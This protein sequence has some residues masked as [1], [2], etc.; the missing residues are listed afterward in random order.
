M[1]CS[2][3][4]AGLFI[5]SAYNLTFSFNVFG[6]RVS[7]ISF[8]FIDSNLS[9]WALSV[10][11]FFVWTGECCYPGFRLRY[12]G[13]S[14]CWSVAELISVITYS[15]IF[16]PVCSYDEQV[17]LWDGRNMRKPF[18]RSLM[19]GGVW[20]LKWHPTNQSLLLA[21]CMHNNFKILNCQSAF[22]KDDEINNDILLWL[23]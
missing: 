5:N 6:L 14:S 15:E 7:C 12:F 1:Y 10:L 13:S 22:G 3:P 21:A 17:L 20:R 9:W 23:N 11:C 19:E 8:K 16:S 18:G 2:L 4:N